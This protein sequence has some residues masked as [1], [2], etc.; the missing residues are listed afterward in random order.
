MSEPS[1]EAVVASEAAANA[2]EEL[3]AREEVDQAA[4]E[5]ILTADTAVEVASNAAVEA[6]AANSNAIYATDAAAEATQTAQAA[7]EQNQAL[8]VATADVI[9]AQESELDR[10]LR[11]MREY[12]DSRIPLPTVEPTTPE[13]EEVEVHGTDVSNNRGQSESASGAKADSAGSAAEKRRYGLKHRSS[14]R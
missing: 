14:K 13:V 3:H 10:K 8:A 5:A 2:V 9:E 4:T 1:P 6:Q 7:L 11:E 12:I